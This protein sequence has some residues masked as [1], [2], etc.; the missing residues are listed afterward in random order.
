[1]AAH[2]ST[3]SSHLLT[4]TFAIMRVAVGA[5]SLFIPTQAAAIFGIGTINQSRIMFR[6]FGAR[7][8]ALGTLLWYSHRRIGIAATKADDEQARRQDLKRLLWI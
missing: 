5:A 3:L 7:E 1:M 6:L 4:R 2:H 8:L